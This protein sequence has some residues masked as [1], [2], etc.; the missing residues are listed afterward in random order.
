MRTWPVFTVL[1]VLA[2]LVA[3]AGCM[4][5]P[6]QNATS[7]VSSASTGNELPGLPG[8]LSGGL[9]L[10]VDSL[11]MGALLPAGNS[12]KGSGT[13]PEVSWIGIPAGTKS[14]VLILDDPDAPSGIFTHWLVYNIPPSADGISSD[15]PAAKVLG[16]GAQQGVNTAG[17][18]GYFPPCPPIGTTHRYVFR[19]YALDAEI[20]QPTADRASVDAAMSGHVLEMS[21][22][23]TTFAR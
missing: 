3:V 11:A 18:R 14:L 20:V 13:S 5:S 21:E 12:C 7:G 17:S 16:N 2:M 8:Q 23:G 15:Q 10:Q 1:A 22:F 9:R 6:A 4:S 19:L